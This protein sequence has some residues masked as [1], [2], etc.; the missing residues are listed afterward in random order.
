M[1]SEVSNTEAFDFSTL[2]IFLIRHVHSITED[3][4]LINYMMLPNIHYQK[5]FEIISRDLSAKTL[6]CS[7]SKVPN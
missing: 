1:I 7:N 6:W 2:L 4:L 5:I 3:V